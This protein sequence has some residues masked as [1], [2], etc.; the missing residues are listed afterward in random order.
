MAFLFFRM[1]SQ[2]FQISDMEE[3]VVFVTRVNS[4]VL[5]R[6]EKQY[7]FT[8]YVARELAK[9]KGKRLDKPKKRGYLNNKTIKETSS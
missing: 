4:E 1:V 8:C 7:R 6:L 5:D 2:S 9:L 3:Q